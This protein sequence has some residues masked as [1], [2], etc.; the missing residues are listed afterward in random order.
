MKKN[1][2][3]FII[4]YVIYAAGAIIAIVFFSANGSQLSR[5]NIDSAV[6]SEEPK[7]VEAKAEEPEIQ[8]DTSAAKEPEISEDISTAEEPE[9]PE[10]I[11]AAKEPE[12]T[13]P[14]TVTEASVTAE[15]AA[16]EATE[17]DSSATEENEKTYY[18]FTVIDGVTGVRIRATKDR[19]SDTISHIDGGQSGYVLE[20]G[21]SRTK[22]LTKKGTIGYIYNDYITIT[23]IPKKDFPKEYR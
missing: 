17:A 7:A 1:Y 19:D 13:E 9:I 14:D 2:I 6:V 8:E 12:V 4:L 15:P 5:Q 18:G 20:Q 21:E 16:D 11:S 22:I 23:T 10:D 3:P